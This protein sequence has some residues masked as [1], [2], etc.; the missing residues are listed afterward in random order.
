MQT[1]PAPSTGV[2]QVHFLQLQVNLITIGSGE[3][4][5]GSGTAFNVSELVVDDITAVYR[6]G[7]KK[8]ARRCA[9]TNCW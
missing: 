9:V 3:G 4:G 6:V 7:C 8:M 1:S 2:W 5:G